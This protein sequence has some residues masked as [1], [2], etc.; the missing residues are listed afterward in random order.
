VPD[1]PKDYVAQNE[2]PEA[3]GMEPEAYEGK[4]DDKAREAPT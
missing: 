2:P 4:G 1:G 3:G